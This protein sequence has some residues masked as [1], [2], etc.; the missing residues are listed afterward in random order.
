MATRYFKANDRIAVCT[1]SSGNRS[2]RI[3]G[4][5]SQ[6]YLWTEIDK[7]E[8]Y[9]LKRKIVNA[10]N[11][12]ALDDDEKRQVSY[13]ANT[14][15]EDMKS[16]LNCMPVHYGLPVLRTVLRTAKRRNEKTRIRVIESEIK[17]LQKGGA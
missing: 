14:S 17:K 15:I 9:R 2:K 13:L 12:Q 3:P 6:S 11:S 7:K 10:G 1:M 16:S 8:F 5:P 4:L